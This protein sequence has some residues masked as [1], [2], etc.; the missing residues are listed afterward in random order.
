[1]PVL[2]SPGD[3]FV[4][5]LPSGNNVLYWKVSGINGGSRVVLE[6]T[7][8]GGDGVWRDYHSIHAHTL[9][10]GEVCGPWVHDRDWEGARGCK[11]GYRHRLRL[12]SRA[13]GDVPTVEMHLYDNPYKAG[14][15]AMP[16]PNA[17]AGPWLYP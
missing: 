2:N 14:R 9:K 17:P 16:A 13:T 4:F 10:P 7:P 6:I 15:L 11:T 3:S 12:L 8:I 5:D 1:M